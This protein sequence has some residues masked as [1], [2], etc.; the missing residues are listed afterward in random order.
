[1]DVFVFCLI[2]AKI[3]CHAAMDSTRRSY[4]LATVLS[5]PFFMLILL[6]LGGVI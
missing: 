2:I 1:M 6:S 3:F 4:G 5:L